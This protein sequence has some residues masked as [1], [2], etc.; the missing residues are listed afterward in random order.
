MNMNYIN[1]MSNLNGQKGTSENYFIKT[2]REKLEKM[3]E[4]I[5][6][7]YKVKIDNLYLS[8]ESL[9]NAINNYILWLK[10]IT[11]NIPDNSNIY[12]Q[13]GYNEELKKSIKKF[14]DSL[15]N[16]SYGNNIKVI[17][18]KNK[19]DNLYKEIISFDF[20]PNEN[21]GVNFSSNSNSNQIKDYYSQFDNQNINNSR[22]EFIDNFDKIEEEGEKQKTYK[23]NSIEESMS[24]RC[25][26]CKINKPSLSFLN[27]LYC[28]ECI[29][30]IV[31]KM[32]DEGKEPNLDD[33]INFDDQKDLFMN[34]FETFI[35]IILLK[36]NYILS[37]KSNFSIITMDHTKE[38]IEKKFNYPIINYNEYKDSDITFMNDINSVLIKEF[39]V[40]FEEF[41]EKNFDLI[42]LN[43]NIRESLK[44]IFNIDEK[45][46]ND[47]KIN[48]IK[49]NIMA[50]EYDNYE[51][52]NSFDF[53]PEEVK[54]ENFNK[55]KISQKKEI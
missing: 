38:I 48:K 18:S 34:S 51:N 12:A 44:N 40:N 37:E 29:D 8:L 41:S 36:C 9:E 32:Y 20:F 31:N 2:L 52:K 16:I 39:E 15:I 1:K 17:D 5:K 24:D 53:N 19:L 21:D 11:P 23:N 10:S 6:T 28:K 26:L 45:I 33:I 50:E 35:K 14:F 43:E 27:K 30:K 47:D 42:K 7:K 22:K 13:K 46:Y 49:N 54:N 25:F 4:E 55:N 3:Q